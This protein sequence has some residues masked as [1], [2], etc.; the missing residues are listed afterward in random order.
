[1]L[2]DIGTMERAKAQKPLHADEY[3]WMIRVYTGTYDVS[4]SEKYALYI[5]VYCKFMTAVRLGI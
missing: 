1:M 2:M 4:S 5:L 3:A